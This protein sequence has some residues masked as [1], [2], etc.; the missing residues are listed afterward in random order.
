M[1]KL[2]YATK[3]KFKIQSMK[4]RLIGF[5]IEILTPYDLNIDI[6]INEDRN[7]VTENAVKK[8]KA[9]SNLVNIPIIAGDSALYIEK[10]KKQPGLY[11]RRGANGK[12]LSDDEL[13]KYYSTELEKVG[14][15]SIAHYVTGLAIINKDRLITTEIKENDF[16]MTSKICNG[17][18]NNDALG[19]LEIDIKSNKYFCEI[20]NNDKKNTDLGYDK[21]CV[22]FIKNNI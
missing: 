3:N 11:V 18:R 1:K 5:D 7:S 19:R 14:G 9:Y 15:E 6:E 4:N 2:F 20:T 10:F 21:K 16:L 17:E 13:E 8:A 22:E 12:Y